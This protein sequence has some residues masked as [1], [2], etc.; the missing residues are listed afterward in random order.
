[1]G[2]ELNE[3]RIRKSQLKENLLFMAMEVAIFYNLCIKVVLFTCKMEGLR[4]P[5]CKHKKEL[6]I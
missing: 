5:Y 6:K 3:D 1:M 4:F 2:T